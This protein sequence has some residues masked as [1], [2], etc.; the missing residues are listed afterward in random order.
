MLRMPKGASTTKDAERRGK[1]RERPM[2]DYAQLLWAIAAL[3]GKR[4]SRQVHVCLTRLISG[5]G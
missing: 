3:V 5:N 2:E 4:D 1:V